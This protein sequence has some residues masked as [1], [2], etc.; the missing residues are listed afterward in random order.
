V[1]A[2]VMIWRRGGPHGAEPPEQVQVRRHLDLLIVIGCMLAA[3]VRLECRVS[4]R[5]GARGVRHNR[6]GL[7][8]YPVARVATAG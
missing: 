2:A 8:G 7:R 1:L 4:P 6:S 5:P 3:T